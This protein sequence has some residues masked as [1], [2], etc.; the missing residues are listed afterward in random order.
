MLVYLNNVNPA[1]ASPRHSPSVYKDQSKVGALV[2]FS[3]YSYAA[4]NFDPLIT[5]PCL[6]LCQTAVNCM[7]RCSRALRVRVC[8]Y[9]SACVSLCAR[10]AACAYMCILACLNRQA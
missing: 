1:G 2:I 8:V 5:V 6:H 3:L 10:A 4:L 7:R 9:V